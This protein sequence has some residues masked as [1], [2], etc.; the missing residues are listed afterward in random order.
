MNEHEGEGLLS[1]IQFSL[2]E[3]KLDVCSCKHLT[4]K[5][6]WVQHA[7][8]AF[9][10]LRPGV[11]AS[12]SPAVYTWHGMEHAWSDPKHRGLALSG[13]KGQADACQRRRMSCGAAN[14]ASANQNRD[15]AQQVKSRKWSADGSEGW[16]DRY[17]RCSYGQ[18]PAFV[19]HQIED[20][21][22]TRGAKLGVCLES[23]TESD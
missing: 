19:F 2:G 16:A 1:F 15:W 21:C 4:D 9:F 8:I 10:F 5:H 13:P 7:S 17:E 3:R 20:C 18:E 23:Q 11:S 6:C 14:T 12:I 22:S